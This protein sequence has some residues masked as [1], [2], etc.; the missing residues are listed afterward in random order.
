MSSTTEQAGPARPDVPTAD[1]HAAVAM[2]VAALLS[3]A[4]QWHQRMRPTN[5]G[6][7]ALERPAYFLLAK[8]DLAGPIRP[9]ALA[10]LVGLDLSTISRHL[11]ALQR[12]GWIVRERDT[13]DRRAQ[14]VRAT[15]DGTRVFE[16]NRQRWFDRVREILADWSDAELQTF[17]QLLARFVEAGEAD[18]HADGDSAAG[19][20]TTSE[21]GK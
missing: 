14:L 6:Q 19:T 5:P 8:I 18:H 15:P 13:E 16:S 17:A 11:T 3:R 12:A 4:H 2:Q 1:P 21:E 9:S 7:P 10:E 20:R